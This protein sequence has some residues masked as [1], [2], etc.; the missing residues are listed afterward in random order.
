[1]TIEHGQIDGNIYLA[2]ELV[3]HGVA[4]GNIIIRAG[5]VLE[6]YGICYQNLIIEPGGKV[7]LHG[8]VIDNVFNRGGY[9][10]IHGA[11]DGYVHTLSGDTIFGPDAAIRLGTCD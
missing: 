6:L 9:V 11:V 1:M 7:Y 5:G 10:E 4:T 3:L 8:L 2:D